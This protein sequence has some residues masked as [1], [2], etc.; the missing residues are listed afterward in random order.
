MNR[1]LTEYVYPN[2]LGDEL[3]KVAISRVH[4]YLLAQFIFPKLMLINL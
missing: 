2:E 3:Y 1:D 4:W